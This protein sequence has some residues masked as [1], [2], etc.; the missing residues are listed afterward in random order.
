M[1]SKRSSTNPLSP[2]DCS[3]LQVKR[4]LK[5]AETKQ[6]LI[7]LTGMNGHPWCMLHSAAKASLTQYNCANW[8]SGWSHPG[9]HL[10][11]D[12]GSYSRGSNVVA[13]GVQGS[14]KEQRTSL[15]GMGAAAQNSR[16]R[17]GWRVLDALRV[18]LDHGGSA[19]LARAR[20]V[21]DHGRPRA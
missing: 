1:S 11:G 19:F 4:P 6:F 16:S 7:G 12:C 20:W 9:Y 3:L 15:Q 13:G 5:K 2:L 17:R 8:L 10:L 21:P 14:D 18:E